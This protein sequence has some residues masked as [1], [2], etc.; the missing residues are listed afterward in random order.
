[1]ILKKKL[2]YFEIT[3]IKDKVSVSQNL[4]SIRNQE[5]SS[6]S[7]RPSTSRRWQWISETETE[8][9]QS[10][11]TE[12]K[13]TL[14]SIHVYRLS[15]NPYF[16]GIIPILLKNSETRLICNQN[17]KNY[18]FDTCRDILSNFHKRKRNAKYLTLMSPKTEE[19]ARNYRRFLT[20]IV[21]LEHQKWYFRASRFKNFLREGGGGG[22]GGGHAPRSP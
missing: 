3:G 16:V 13:Q 4:W 8:I 22:G 2:P 18:D 17:R 15:N 5:I 11:F 7:A 10:S 20:E 9:G 1:M 21:V 19:I 12:D 14:C 6:T